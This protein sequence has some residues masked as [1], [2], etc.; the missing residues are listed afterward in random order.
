M[1][2]NI[3]SPDRGQRFRSIQ[4][5]KPG[6]IQ[7]LSFIISKPILVK[8]IMLAAQNPLI[9]KELTELLQSIKL[10]N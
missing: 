2:G 7:F 4:I 9:V 3:L 5:P 10:Y 8:K 6:M 1:T